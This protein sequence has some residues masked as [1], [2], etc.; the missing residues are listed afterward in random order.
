MNKLNHTQPTQL[1][2]KTIVMWHSRF[3]RHHLPWQNTQDR[4]KVWVS[5]IMLQQTQVTTVIG[6]FERF[7][8][9]YP[10]VDTLANAHIEEVL[11]LW[12]GLGYYRRA[13]HLHESAKIIVKDHHSIV[14]SVPSVLETLPGIGRSTANAICSL[15]NNLPY[16]ILD[17]NVKRIFARFFGIQIPKETTHY[18][19]TL[20][21][22]AH[23]YLSTTHSR[24]YNQ[25]L[26]DI[27]ATLCLPKN[28]ACEKCPLSTLD[29]Y[30]HQHNNVAEL[31]VK[32][33]K[34]KIKKTIKKVFM[35]LIVTTKTPKQVFLTQRDDKSFWPE[36]WVLPFFESQEQLEKTLPANLKTKTISLPPITHEFTHISWYITPLLI[37]P[38]SNNTTMTMKNGQWYT[39]KKIAHIPMPAPIKQ[40]IKKHLF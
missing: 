28:A 12:A 22:I 9:T 3:G 8:T 1:F 40:L 33:P 17:G 25:A 26:M 38:I 23:L 7:M 24:I 39:A 14:P 32:N 35:A 29:C 4:Y 19:R 5:E 15:S 16:P 13:K 20:W 21:Q 30:A 37:T 27:G 2:S 18:E 34:K 11:A 36:L 31:P 10:N 6:Y